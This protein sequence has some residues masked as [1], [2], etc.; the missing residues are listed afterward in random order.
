MTGLKMFYIYT[1]KENGFKKITS[2]HSSGKLQY[3]IY[4]YYNLFFLHYIR[5]FHQLNNLK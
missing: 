2:F 5:G 4:I 1:H 3:F